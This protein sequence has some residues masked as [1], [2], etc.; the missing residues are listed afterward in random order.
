MQA[1]TNRQQFGFCADPH[2]MQTWTRS[3]GGFLGYWTVVQGAIMVL[4]SAL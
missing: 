4:R 1:I 2:H 3:P